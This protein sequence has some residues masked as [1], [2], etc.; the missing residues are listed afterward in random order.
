M[1]NYFNLRFRYLLYARH[2]YGFLTLHV[3]VGEV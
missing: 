2:V 3:L 1:S